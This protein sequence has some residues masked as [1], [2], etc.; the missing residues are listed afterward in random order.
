MW[1]HLA[2]EEARPG[3]VGSKRFLVLA[4]RIPR[5]TLHRSRKYGLWV[6]SSPASLQPK[7]PLRFT[8]ASQ[9]PPQAPR[10]CSAASEPGIFEPFSSVSACLPT[11]GPHLP[12]ERLC[13][14]SPVRQ[15]CSPALVLLL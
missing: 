4:S 5:F 3:R 2:G 10:P 1:F 7:S 14:S 11:A 13:L 8:F 6:S 9:R 15:P 12:G